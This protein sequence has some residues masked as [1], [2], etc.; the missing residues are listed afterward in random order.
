[1]GARAGLAAESF[2]AQAG[3]LQGQGRQLVQARLD[4]RAYELQFLFFAVWS[5]T[6]QVAVGILLET[7]HVAMLALDVFVPLPKVAVEASH[8][9]VPFGQVPR[10]MCLL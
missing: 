8:S 1:M 4:L 9:G 3:A 6:Y 7:A 10:R 2:Q 5:Y